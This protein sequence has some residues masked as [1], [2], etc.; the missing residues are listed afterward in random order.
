M[1]FKIR[2][3]GDSAIGKIRKNNQDSIF[4]DEKVKAGIVADGV[5]GRKGGEVASNIV[6]L[7]F[8]KFVQK[9]KIWAAKSIPELYSALIEDINSKVFSFGERYKN[10]S[11]LGT[12]LTA[13]QF[14]DNQLFIPHC[15]DSRTYLFA[16]NH[17]FQLTIDHNVASSLKHGW[18]DP[19]SIPQKTKKT[20]LTRGIG[21]A[22]HVDIDIYQMVVEPKAILLDLQ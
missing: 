19:K 12:T 2:M 22:K 4:Y 17:L 15:G 3:F 10:M 1:S 18:L 13:V 9:N 16:N 8:A 20:V 14:V 11:G 7:E 21:L 6:A 5:G